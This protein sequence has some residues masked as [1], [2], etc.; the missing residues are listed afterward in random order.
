MALLLSANH[1]AHHTGWLYISNRMKRPEREVD[2]S[3]R[4]RS[5]VSGVLKRCLMSRN[6]SRWVMEGPS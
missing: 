6:V 1:A 2:N 5:Q 4:G 3:Y